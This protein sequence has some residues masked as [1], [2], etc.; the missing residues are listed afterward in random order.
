MNDNVRTCSSCG[1]QYEVTIIGDT[2]PGCRE[3]EEIYCPHCHKKDGA[4]FTSGVP[5]TSAVD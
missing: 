5:H 1:R 4:I 2:H 3:M